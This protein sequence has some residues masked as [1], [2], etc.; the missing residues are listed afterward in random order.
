MSYTPDMARLDYK[1]EVQR[2]KIAILTHLWREACLRAMGIVRP[3][4]GASDRTGGDPQYPWRVM[5][6]A[7]G[8]LEDRL[9]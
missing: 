9:K 4:I 3:D 7:R 6:A 5:N 2:R 8:I 1:L